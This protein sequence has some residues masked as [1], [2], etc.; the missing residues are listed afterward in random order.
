MEGYPAFMDWKITF[1]GE[2]PYQNS[3]I[4]ESFKYYEENKT[5]IRK[6]NLGYM[7][8]KC[9]SEEVSSVSPFP[10]YICFFELGSNP[11]HTL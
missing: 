8:R 11:V 6:N 10:F 4:S 2:S 9:L 3:S 5:V 7:V 1:D